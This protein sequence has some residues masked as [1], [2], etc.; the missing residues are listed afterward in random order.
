MGRSSPLPFLMLL[1]WTALCGCTPGP[2]SGVPAGRGLR[3]VATTGMVADLVR[4]VVGDR[5]TVQT[6]M[7]AGVDPHLYKPTTSDIADIQQADVVFYNGLGLEG[8]MEP[9]FR[10]SAERGRKVVAVAGTLPE[11]AVE[12][13]ATF[14]GHADPHVWM[15]VGLWVECLA[16]VVSVLCQAAPEHAAEFQANADTYRAALMELDA[17]ARRAIESI[18]KE[19]RVLVT[20]HDAFSYF[21]KSYGIEV[22]AVQ[23]ITTESEPGVDD[24]NSLVRF[25]VASGIP[26][27]FVESSVNDR[28]L[29]AVLEGVARHGG[30]VAIGGRLYSDAMGPEGTYEGT[31]VGMIDHNVTVIARAL[32]GDAP[33]GGMSGKLSTPVSAAG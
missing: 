18:P 21:S 29:M 11:S 20:A 25:L 3:I 26:A 15:N 8:P 14:K 16:P 22:K 2:S 32:G 19:R 28:N 13:S 17:Y 24:I 23:G 6:L 33:A 12:H 5:G 30:K 31:Y 9:I 1:F 7:S 27:L 10:R 4:H